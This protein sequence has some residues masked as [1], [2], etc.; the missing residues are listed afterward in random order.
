MRR[1]AEQRPNEQEHERARLGDLGRLETEE[2]NRR[3]V[4]AAVDRAVFDQ[5]EVRLGQIPRERRDLLDAVG[6]RG[7][8]ED[9]RLGVRV[10]SGP[11]LFGAAGVALRPEV[12]VLKPVV[13]PAVNAQGH[14][15]VEDQ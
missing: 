7:Q 10:E 8:R 15:A 13:S 6:C 1:Y 11:P 9:T 4:D 3:L 12:A 14:R 5:A 2:L